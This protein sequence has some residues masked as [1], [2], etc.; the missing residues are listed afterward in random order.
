M[1]N[2]YL[3][4]LAATLILGG[5]LGDRSDRRGAADASVNAGMQ[6]MRQ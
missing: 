2:A 1:T 3:L 6:P 5:K 4:A